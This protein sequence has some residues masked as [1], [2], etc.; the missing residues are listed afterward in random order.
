VEILDALEISHIQ[1]SFRQS[2]LYGRK[3][4]MHKTELFNSN[5]CE[6]VNM[7][8]AKPHWRWDV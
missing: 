4:I 1:Y 2:T 7:T 5:T 3:P 8:I 6:M